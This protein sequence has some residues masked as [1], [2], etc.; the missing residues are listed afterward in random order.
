VCAQIE[1]RRKITADKQAY[2]RN[3]HVQKVMNIQLKKQ[4]KKEWNQ[5]GK[6]QYAPHICFSQI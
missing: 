3:V 2:T 6:G 4:G 1:Q 5:Q